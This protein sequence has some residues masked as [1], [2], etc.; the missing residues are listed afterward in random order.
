MGF[1]KSFTAGFFT[2]CGLTAVG[3]PCEDGGEILPMHGTIS[4][5]PC[6]NVIHFIE[7]NEI[8]IKLTVRD[9][10]LFS[11]QLL[12][13]REYVCPISE[14]VI[15]LT[16][17]IR[18]IGSSKRRLRYFI[19]AIW[20]IRFVGKFQGHDSVRQGCG[21]RRSRTGRHRKMS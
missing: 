6:E 18:N 1:L 15:Y 19:I 3:S 17:R 2:T 7:N 11:H 13:E 10:S 4:N 21:K 12:L 8:H 5:T 9:A 16:D 14:N 20:V